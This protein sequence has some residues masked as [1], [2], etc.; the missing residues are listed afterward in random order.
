MVAVTRRGGVQTEAVLLPRTRLLTLV[1]SLGAG[2]LNPAQ[3]ETVQALWAA[4]LALAR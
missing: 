3:R 4:V 1:D 2:I